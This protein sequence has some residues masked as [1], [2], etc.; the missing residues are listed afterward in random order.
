MLI[1]I[2]FAGGLVAVTMAMYAVGFDLLLRA[3]VRSHALAA[4]GFR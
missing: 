2:L 4:S 3:M 1:K